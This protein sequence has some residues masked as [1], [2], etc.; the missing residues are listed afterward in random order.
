MTREEDREREIQQLKDIALRARE[1]LSEAEEFI[2][3]VTRPPFIYGTVISVNEDSVDVDVNGRVMEVGYNPEILDELIPGAGARLNPETYAVIETRERKGGNILTSIEEILEDGSVV[4]NVGGRRQ[5]LKTE[6]EV[7]EGDRITVD[8]NFRIIL[9]NFGKKSNQHHVAE[10]PIVPWSKIGGLESAIQSLRDAIEEPFIYKDIYA[11]YGKRAPKGVLLHGPSGCGKTLL[12]KAVAYNLSERL[13]KQGGQSNGNGYFLSVK[14]PDLKTM[15]YGESERG[16]RELFSTGR[17][18]SRQTG[19]V[20]VM[21]LD[22]AESLFGRRGSKMGGGHIDDSLVNQ[23]LAEMDGMEANHNIV[24]ILA[25]NRADMID[26]A[27]LRPGRIDKRIRVG[28]PNN[29]DSVRDIFG[30]HLG[31]MPVYGN[32]ATRDDHNTLALAK[33]ASEHLFGSEYPIFDVRFREG[34]FA[35]VGMEHLTSGAM[36]ESISQR[37]AGKAIKRE[38]GGKKEGLT[39]DDLTDSI[40]DEYSEFKDLAVCDADDLREI[41]PKRYDSIAELNRSYNRGKHGH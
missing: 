29:Q 20:T 24:L 25:T 19:D 4:V 33:Y 28:R 21:F 8:P 5:V 26:S 2:V 37:A 38:I 36:I 3:H 13:K 6:E 34:D 7:R 12:G 32:G 17:E 30:I 27:V 11:R 10:I 9:Q 39:K 35:Y 16:I 41:F 40:R 23:F 31:G 18:N 14:G 1:K 15:W 22:E